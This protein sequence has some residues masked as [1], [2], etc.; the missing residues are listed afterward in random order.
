MP[1]LIK[2]GKSNVA[3][4]EAKKRLLLPEPRQHFWLFLAIVLIPLAVLIFYTLNPHFSISAGAINGIVILIMLTFLAALVALVVA[5][6]KLLIDFWKAR[7]DSAYRDKN[8]IILILLYLFSLL[9]F[10]VVF[11]ALAI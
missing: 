5:F 3:L 10:V 6:I 11:Q 8:I 7:F 4:P 9:M 2:A 1:K